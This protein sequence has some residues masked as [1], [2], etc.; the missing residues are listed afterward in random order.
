MTLRS[1][2]FTFLVCIA[3]VARGAED[4]AAA[5]P[6]ATAAVAAPAAGAEADA[7]E[8]AAEDD[9]LRPEVSMELGLFGKYIWRMMNYNSHPVLQPDLSATVYGF[10]AEVWGVRDLTKDNRDASGNLIEL[11]WALYYGR[12]LDLAKVGLE[13]STMEFSAG[14]WSYNYPNTD[15]PSTHELFVS[16]S[17]APAGIGEYFA[18]GVEVY[19]DIEDARDALWVEPKIEGGYTFPKIDAPVYTEALNWK[20]FT[21]LSNRA[22]NRFNFVDGNGDALNE[23]AWVGGGVLLELPCKIEGAD[24]LTITPSMQLTTIWDSDARDGSDHPDNFMWGLTVG[25][26]F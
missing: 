15:G 23:T 1:I 13:D 4:P 19:Y 24:F 17:I 14:M 6:D 20:L 10:T 7:A 18:P 11:D 26:S 22:Y 5:A 25:V 21:G 3:I 12:E 16:A 9:P 8:G 2:L